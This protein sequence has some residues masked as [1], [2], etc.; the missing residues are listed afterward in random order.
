MSPNESKDKFIRLYSNLPL[1]VRQ[2][3]V[4]VMEDNE[5]ITWNIAYKEIQADTKLGNII[6]SKLENL[7]FI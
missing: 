3:V 7:D 6:L 4:L 1:N 2:E 5:P